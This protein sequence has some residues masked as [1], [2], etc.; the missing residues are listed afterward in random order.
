VFR[1]QERAD[2]KDTERRMLAAFAEQMAIA[3]QNLQ[4][5][6][7][8]AE[9]KKRLEAVIENSADGIMTVDRDRRIIGYNAALE[10]LTGWGRAEVLQRFCGDVLQSQDA[11]GRSLCRED[12]PLLRVFSSDE[13]RLSVEETIRTRDGQPVSVLATFSVIRS[14]SGEP[15]GGTVNFRDVTQQR[16]LEDLRSTFLSVV[17]HEL[18]TPIAIIKGYAGTLARADAAWDGHTIRH[19]LQSIE[20]ETDRLGRLVENL[21]SISRIEAGGIALRPAP[22]SVAPLVRRTVRKLAG[23]S[24]RH[25]LRVELP[26]DL[27]TVTGDPERLEEVL[28]NLVENAIKYSPGGGEVTIS[29]SV[30]RDELVVRVQDQGI[31]VGVRDRE[32]IFDRFYRV[33]G[34]LARRTQGTGLGLFICRAIVAAHGGRIWV[35]SALSRG[36]TFSFSLPLEQK[37]FLP[38]VSFTDELG[39]AVG[40]AKQSGLSA[41]AEP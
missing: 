30:E 6:F 19:G 27:P 22:V 28:L 36:S 39:S 13:P 23:R 4:L 20:E 32:R 29:A 17:S 41:P 34:S 37:T 26:P 18:Q 8:L 31:G 11:Q 40:S 38:V 10:R 2:F 33:D 9:E 14:P 3:A 25:S 1:R 35:E 16:E 15:I 7:E 21:L 12:C 5:L 24:A